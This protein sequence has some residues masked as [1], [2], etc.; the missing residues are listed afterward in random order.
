[1]SRH[2]GV[3][4]PD[5]FL[6]RQTPRVILAGGGIDQVFEDVILDDLGDRDRGP[7]SIFAVRLHA[8]L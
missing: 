7:V 6:G 4:D 1:M 2:V 5:Q 3:D 8:Q